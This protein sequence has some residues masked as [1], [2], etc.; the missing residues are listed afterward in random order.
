MLTS[1]VG[2]R[3]TVS[4]RFETHS[5]PI[6]LHFN[7]FQHDW[8][9]GEGGGGGFNIAVQQNRTDVEANVEVVSP[10]LYF[11][12]RKGQRRAAFRVGHYHVEYKREE[13]WSSDQQWPTHSHILELDWQE[14]YRWFSRFELAAISRVGRKQ[15]RE[16]KNGDGYSN[17]NAKKQ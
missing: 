17:D 3:Q 12:I 6:Q 14:R 7:M 11:T 2:I 4:T 5:T 1:G 10:G 15:N 9:E 13:I 8:K 16:F